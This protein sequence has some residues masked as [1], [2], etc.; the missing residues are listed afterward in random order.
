MDR[1]SGF[2]EDSK[3]FED[4][5]GLRVRIPSGSLFLMVILEIYSLL[6]NKYRRQLWWPVTEEGQIKPEYTGGPKNDKQRLEVAIG[7]V[8]TQNTSWKNAE[9]AIMN[10]NRKS[11]IDIEK[12]KKIGIKELDEV[13]RPSGFYRQKTER[14]KL[15]AEFLES[16]DFSSIKREELIR[17]KGIG[18]E[19]ADSILLYACGKP[20]FV[21]DA[22]TKRIFNRLGLIN[23]EN[24]EEVKRLFQRA[25]TGNNN[26]IQTYQEFHALIVEHAKQH[27]KKEPECASCPIKKECNYYKQLKQ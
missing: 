23:T 2:G 20:E 18:P 14:L 27:C 6:L 12:I 5:G 11:L 22:Y 19:T 16:R 1:A 25:L 15:L 3:N 26:L 24:Y 13:V 7:A 8:L 4:T 17:I 9:K 21:V 10:L